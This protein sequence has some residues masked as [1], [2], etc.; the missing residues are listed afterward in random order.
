MRR[1]ALAVTALAAATVFAPSARGDVIV[2]R[3]A[4][5]RPITLDV[6]APD[7]DAA[8]YAG[9]LS[10]AAHGPEIAG[11]VVRIVPWDEVRSLCGGGAGACYSRRGGRARIV[12]PAGKGAT[13]AHALIHEYAHH[14]DATH[15]VP[16]APE[17]NGTPGWWQARDMERLV[18]D[19]LVSTTYARGWQRSIGEIFAEDYTQL[20]LETEYGIGWLD[21]PDEV[22]LEALR[23]DVAGAPA[24]PLSFEGAPLVAVRSGTLRRGRPFLVPFGLLGP[25]RRVTMTVRLASAPP[26]GARARL[27]LRCGSATPVRKWVPRGG[28]SVTL[29]RRRLGPARCTIS[30]RGSPAAPVRF[31]ATLRLAVERPLSGGA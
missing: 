26:P 16:G 12:V 5:G 18:G 24:E 29:D 13:V 10:A 28:R 21:A 7:V 23:E 2:K 17:P 9:L 14:V 15:R 27:E 3:D 1:L 4:A 22:V 20:H 19:D 11:V 30:L 6:R 31:T 8:W 25:G